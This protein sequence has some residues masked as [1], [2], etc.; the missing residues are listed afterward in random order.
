MSTTQY[1]IVAVNPYENDEVDEVIGPFDSKTLAEEFKKDLLAL[2]AHPD[3]GWY[4][5]P[6]NVPSE[7]MQRTKDEMF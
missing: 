4:I 5:L 3:A 7:V 6:L 2:E 1:V